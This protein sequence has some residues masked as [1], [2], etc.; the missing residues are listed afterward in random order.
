[1]D[2]IMF[3][4]VSV[5]AWCFTRLFVIAL[6]NVD[7]SVSAGCNTDTTQEKQQHSQPAALNNTDNFDY[8]RSHKL[9]MERVYI[10]TLNDV[11][12]P[13]AQN[14]TEVLMVWKQTVADYITDFNHYDAK[15]KSTSPQRQA[16]SQ[17]SRSPCR[18]MYLNED[19][20]SWLH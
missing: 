13:D 16:H 5:L 4:L 10:D 3:A 11:V 17:A 2:I 12:G 9:V 15:N 18:Q 14:T 19:D 20:G 8:Q 1:M 7:G 6:S